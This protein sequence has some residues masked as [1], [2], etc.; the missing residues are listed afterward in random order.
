MEPC[1]RTLQTALPALAA[2]GAIVFLA[3]V[4]ATHAAS[5]KDDIPTAQRIV[6]FTDA[7]IP[8]HESSAWT[9]GW[10]WSVMALNAATLTLAGLALLRLPGLAIGAAALLTLS[11]SFLMPL[12]NCYLQLHYSLSGTSYSLTRHA[13]NCTFAGSGDTPACC[14]KAKPQEESK[15]APA[16]VTIT[17]TDANSQAFIRKTEQAAAAA[18]V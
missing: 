12:C 2:V 9:F 8:A 4:A 7:G 3:G 13:V 15:P 11:T 18:M 14:R 6:F 16:A 1:C 17:A 10:S 5:N